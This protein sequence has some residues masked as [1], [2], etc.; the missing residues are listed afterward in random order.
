[1]VFVGDVAGAVEVAKDETASV[2]CSFDEGQG[3][4]VIDERLVWSKVEIV[5]AVFEIDNED[6]VFV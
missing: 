6:S 3:L 1:M 4:C 2:L 5:V